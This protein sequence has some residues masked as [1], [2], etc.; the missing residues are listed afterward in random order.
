MVFMFWNKG[1]KENAHDI[2][3]VIFTYVLVYPLQAL[4]LLFLRPPSLLLH[5]LHFLSPTSSFSLCASL[6]IYVPQSSAIGLRYFAPPFHGLQGKEE[7]HTLFRFAC[8]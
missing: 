3:L 2:I 1:S 5:Y 7:T 8:Y 6:K 4:L